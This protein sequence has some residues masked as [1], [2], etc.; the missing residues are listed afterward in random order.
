MT[1]DRDGGAVPGAFAT[2]WRAAVQPASRP[3][4]RM[5][6]FARRSMLSA[7]AAV[8]RGSAD[9]FVR[10][11]YCHYVFD[12]QR[13]DFERIIVRL[14]DLGT[15]VGTEQ[16]LAMLVGERPVDG[17]YFHLSFDDGF[18][19]NFTNALPILRKHG[20]PAIFFV[21]S[22]LIGADW[23]RTRTYCLDVTHYR[24]VI[25]TLRWDDL[26]V[27]LDAGYEVGSHTR[28][29]ARFS[30]MSSDHARLEDEILGSK[31]DL[32][33]AL[34]Y[35]CRYISWPYGRTTDADMSSVGF[36]KAVGYDACFGAFRGSV[37]A[38]E[39]DRYRIPRHHFEPQ[40]QPAHVEYF[41]RGNME[42]YG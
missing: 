22:G 27:M 15:F 33:T 17:R 21:P 1:H 28:T 6:G 10:C 2:S 16:L 32:E 25:E 37:I 23:D 36:T 34:G 5:R 40:W 13:T 4:D 19:N 29:H 9:R 30:A 20:V 35:R 14:K 31:Q 3:L 18:R 42:A 39:T 38:G 41:A 12:D 11:L 8:R 26:K 7:L 24:S